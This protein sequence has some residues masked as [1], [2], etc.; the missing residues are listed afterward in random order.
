[1]T[2]G[3]APTDPGAWP[4]EPP[5][6][7]QLALLVA[8]ALGCEGGVVAPEAR[9]SDIC[10]DSLDL[11][12]LYVTLD[13]WVPGFV[14]PRQLDLDIATMADVHHYLVMR[15]EQRRVRR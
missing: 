9:V 12:C 6:F 3:D 10:A 13:A 1:M 14:L 2:A 5:D 15:F 11:Y 4:D 7:D 8:G